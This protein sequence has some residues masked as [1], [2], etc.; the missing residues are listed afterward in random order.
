[1]ASLQAQPGNSFELYILSYLILH[2]GRTTPV[3]EDA[4]PSV[5][6]MF[7]AKRQIKAEQQ[8]RIF[9]T[10]E[11]TSRVS[12]LDPHSDHHDFT[13]FYVLFWIGLAIMAMTTMLRNIKDTGFPMRVEIWQLFTVKVWELGVADGLM[14]A[15]TSISLPFH[16]FF[17][18]KMGKALG[19]QWTKGGMAIQSLYQIFWIAFWVS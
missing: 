2:S 16:K 5:Q 1:M 12:H 10:I 4:P 8:H 3:P 13:G 9:P 15:S 14:V 18:S 6:S 11:Y 17:R 19:F 7:S